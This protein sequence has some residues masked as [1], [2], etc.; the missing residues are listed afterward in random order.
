LPGLEIKAQRLRLVPHVPAHLLALSE[1]GERYEAVTGH[2]PA[3]GLREFLVS[4]E[5]SQAWVDA[6]RSAREP[7]PWLHGFAA[8]HEELGCVIGTGAFKGPP[9]D[10][11]TAELAYAIVPAFEGQGFATEVAKAL[12]EF[13]SADERVHLLRAHTLPE[14]NAS[15]RVLAKCGFAFVGEVVDPD[16]GPVWR[17]ERRP[18]GR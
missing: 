12:V 2:R 17:W 8:I 16:D 4:P 18:G 15:T 13:A 1:S 9:D 3:P 6:L 5:V 11:G 10:G 14:S 7:D